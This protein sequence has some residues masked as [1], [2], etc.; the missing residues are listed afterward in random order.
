MEFLNIIF[1]NFRV[2]NTSDFRTTLS[3]VFAD[4]ID[5]TWKLARITKKKGNFLSLF[6]LD[7]T[8]VINEI[9]G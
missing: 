5:G 7:F 4:K 1:G 8:A 2:S 6:G 3:H 9:N